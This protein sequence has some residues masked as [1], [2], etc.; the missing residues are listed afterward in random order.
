M[1][2]I[3]AD[4]FRALFGLWPTGVSIVTT[5]DLAGRHFGLTMNSITSVSLEPPLLLVCLANES[6]TLDAICDSRMFCINLLASDQEDLSRRFA[7]RSADK[8][9]GVS[10]SNGHLGAPILDGVLGA[11]ECRVRDIFPGGD[12]RIVVGQCIHGEKFNDDAAPLVFVRSRYG[13]ALA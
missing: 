2:S 4:E 8:F 7:H 13:A 1:T 10:F 5:R 3:S 6:E 11:M 12:H 9:Q